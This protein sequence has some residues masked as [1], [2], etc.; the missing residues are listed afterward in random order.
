MTLQRDPVVDASKDYEPRLEVDQ[1]QLALFREGI[2][3]YES[4]ETPV[5]V[6]RVAHT[7]GP[8]SV[9]EVKDLDGTVLFHVIY[10]PDGKHLSSTWGNPHLGNARLIAA[11]PDLLEALQQALLLIETDEMT[12]GRKFVAGNVAREAIARA[13]G[14]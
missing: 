6:P 12:H 13:T 2:D 4:E 7:P 14:Q 10:A 1:A 9:E 5:Q 8:W 3:R 11:A